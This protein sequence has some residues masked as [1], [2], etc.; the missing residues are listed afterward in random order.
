MCLDG[1]EK[2]NVRGLID[3]SDR[4]TTRIDVGVEPLRAILDIFNKRFGDSVVV[5]RQQQ[6]NTQKP[7][8]G[9]HYETHREQIIAAFHENKGVLTATERMLNAR[10]IRCSRRWLSVYL[11]NWGEYS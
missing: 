2:D 11:K 7:T 10:G 1:F 5:A 8:R 9:S 4:L 3:L 6:D